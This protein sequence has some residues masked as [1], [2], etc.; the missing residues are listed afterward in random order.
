MS[1]TWI[2]FRFLMSKDLL[3]TVFSK[4]GIIS[5]FA[6]VVFDIRFASALF[7]VPRLASLSATLL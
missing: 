3:L 4:F 7:D 5:Y 2:Q 6:N 1:V